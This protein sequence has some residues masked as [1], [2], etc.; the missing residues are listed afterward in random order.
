MVSTAA[1]PGGT[2]GTAYSAGLA[3]LGG[4][5]P[6]SWAAGGLPGGLGVSGASITGTP[7]AVGN[8]NITVTVTDSNSPAATASA[9]L[10]I[11]IIPGY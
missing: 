1:L 5:P 6:Y 9:S 10:S 11:D 8:F 2:V 7:T 4:V 3:A